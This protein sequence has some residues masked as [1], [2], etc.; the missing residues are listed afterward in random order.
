VD[1]R[2]LVQFALATLEATMAN[3][4]AIGVAL[5]DRVS[6]RIIGYAL[7]SALENHDEE[8]VGAD[9][10][11][12]DNNTFFLQALATQPAVRNTV[13]L[14]HRLLESIRERAV[15]DGFAFLSTLIEDRVRLEGPPW[16]TGATV[17]DRIE[18]YLRTGIDFVYLQAPIAP[19]SS[20]ADRPAPPQ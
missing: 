6:G 19:E 9:P 16:L 15:A 5:R 8:G 1:G 11:Y 20:S 14:E 13:E 3:P 12:G 2:P 10:H 4:H 7:G 18:N 17:L